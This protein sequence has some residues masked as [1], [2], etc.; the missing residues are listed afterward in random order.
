MDWLEQELKRALDRKEPEPGFAG[1]VVAATRRRRTMPRWMAVAASVVALAG[2]GAGYRWYEG[3][4]TK[5]E[6]ML[7]LRVA[8]GKLNHVQARVMEVRR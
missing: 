2:G 3:V 5:D 4:R 8:G 1:R 7:A 6:V